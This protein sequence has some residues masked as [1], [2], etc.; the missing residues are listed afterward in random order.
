MIKIQKT[1]RLV[2][3]PVWKRA[4]QRTIANTE[5]MPAPTEAEK[6]DAIKVLA[7]PDNEGEPS[8]WLEAHKVLDEAGQ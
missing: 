7:D 4:L 1:T 8:L 6:A 5:K 2:E 3:R